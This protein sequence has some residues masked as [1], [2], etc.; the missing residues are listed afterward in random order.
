M[1]APQS[2]TGAQKAALKWLINRNADGVFD[3]H[4]VLPPLVSGRPS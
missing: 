3:R 4:Q 2:I 1:S